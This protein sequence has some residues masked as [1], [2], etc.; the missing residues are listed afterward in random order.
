MTISKA[1]IQA[2]IDAIPWYHEF[3][4]GDG[5]V[6]LSKTPDIESHRANWRF[7]HEQL[8]KF[9]FAN[10]TV[11]D[12]GCWDGYWSFDAERRGARSVLAIDD[13][14]QNWS[15]RR[16]ILLARDLLGSKVEVNPR[17]SVHELT[18]LGRK[19]DVILFLGVYYHLMDPYHALSQIRQC[20]HEDT[21]VLIEGSE[22]FGLPPNAVLFDVENTTCRYLPSAGALDHLLRATYFTRTHEAFMPF[23][24]SFLRRGGWRFR[25]RAALKA[26]RGD[27]RELARMIQESVAVRRLFLAATPFTGRNPAHPYRPPFGLAAFDPLYS[28]EGAWRPDSFESTPEPHALDRAP[29]RQR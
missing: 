16:G 5:L 13:F 7:I 17:L 24:T 29:A 14:S 22:G 15:D 28:T 26:L 27:R 1:S 20:C 12:I 18:S 4:F 9:D 2:Q 3:D 10:K 19:F 6:A 21:I 25:L 23:P 8:D 11:L